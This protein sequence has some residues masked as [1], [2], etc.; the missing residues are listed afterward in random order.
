MD[1][2][3]PGVS[4]QQQSKTSSGTLGPATRL[5]N[6]FLPSSELALAWK[7]GFTHQKA[8]T[9]PG[10][11]W[12][13]TLHTSEPAL[14]LGAPG[15]L[16]PAA[17]CLALPT[18]S[19]QPPYKPKCTSQVDIGPTRPTRPPIVVRP[20]NRRAHVAHT[21]R[22]GELLE[23]ITLVIKGE[24][25]AGYTGHLLQKATSPRLGNVLTHHI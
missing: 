17:S 23:H 22:D 13:L 6:P 3:H 14:A 12:T 7:P 18:S 8:G 4:A 16:Q 1:T 21:G 9:S 20:P 2:P 11:S 15:V 19:Q 5:Q 10:V 24:Y 25:A